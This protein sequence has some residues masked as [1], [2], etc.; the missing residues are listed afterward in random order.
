M[1]LRPVKLRREEPWVALVGTVQTRCLACGTRVLRARQGCP[2]HGPVK[3]HEREPEGECSQS[4]GIECVNFPGYRALRVLGHGGF[5]TVFEA[6]PV[7]GGRS[8]AIKLARRDKSHAAQ[9]LA[10]ELK[11]LRDVGPPHVPA[12]YDAG[13]LDNGSLY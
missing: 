13:K 12:V 4:S 11:A 3:A 6:M 8:V 1:L 5:G 7:A 10:R 9:Q 2:E